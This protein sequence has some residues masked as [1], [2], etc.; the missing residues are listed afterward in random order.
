M[1]S[2]ILFYRGLCLL[3]LSL[4]GGCATT[5]HIANPQS[6][7]PELGLRAAMEDVEVKIH[8]VI[9][10]DGPGSWVQ[11]AKWTEWVV[12]IAN[13]GQGDVAIGRISVI[14]SSGVYVDS[15]RVGPW[16]EKRG[17]ESFSLQ[18]KRADGSGLNCIL[19][20]FNS[21]SCSG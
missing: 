8:H 17:Q 3:V 9:V 19:R 21:R 10:P 13:R 12:S 5:R 7:P 14:D 18:A 20:H 15:G 16:V 11:G 1:N 4:L 6:P 2:K